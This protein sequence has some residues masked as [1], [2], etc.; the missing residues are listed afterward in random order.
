[1][2]SGTFIYAFNV[3]AG[4]G[5]LLAPLPGAFLPSRDLDL[6]T[7]VVARDGVPRDEAPDVL[8]SWVDGDGGLVDPALDDVD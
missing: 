5:L 8:C 2:G 1:M 3:D 7:G 6:P 4:A